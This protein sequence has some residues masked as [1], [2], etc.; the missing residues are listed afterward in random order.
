VSVGSNF[1]VL[2]S[3]NR[4]ATN[5]CLKPPLVLF[6]DVG[7]ERHLDPTVP[8]GERVFNRVRDIDNGADGGG[9]AFGGSVSR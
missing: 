5:D 7:L 8:D 9:K 4:Y 3:R 1:G 6:K 2:G